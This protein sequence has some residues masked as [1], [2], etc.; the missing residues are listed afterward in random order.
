MRW[1]AAR[2]NSAATFDQAAIGIAHNHELRRYLRVNRKLC[3]MLGLHRSGD[4]RENL[5]RRH[6][7]AD[8]ASTESR[9]SKVLGEAGPGGVEAESAMSARTGACCG[10]RLRSRWCATTGAGRSIS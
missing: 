1:R 4:A 10:S 8:L 7:P 5:P 2:R 6:P 9:M 3:D